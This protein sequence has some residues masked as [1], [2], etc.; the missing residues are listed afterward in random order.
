MVSIVLHGFLGADRVLAPVH[1]D[2]GVALVLVDDAGLHLPVPAEDL[3]QLGFRARDAAHE[4]SSAQHLD[5][6]VGQRVVVLHPLVLGRG[7]GLRGETAASGRRALSVVVVAAPSPAAAAALGRVVSV[8]VVAAVTV[9][10]S[11]STVPSSR[12]R[13]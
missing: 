3:A 11:I 9:R 1:L 12:R 4:K 7:L 13:P 10:W 6:T 5:V 2:E 8:V